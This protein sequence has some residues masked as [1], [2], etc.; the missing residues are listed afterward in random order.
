[1]HG[2]SESHLRAGRPP[3]P[4]RQFA[5]TLQ[6]VHLLNTQFLPDQAA[7]LPFL[8]IVNYG[9]HLGY[10]L[11]RIVGPY[12]PGQ[13]VTGYVGIVD[14]D[15]SAAGGVEQPLSDDA[16]KVPVSQGEDTLF[17]DGVVPGYGTDFPAN[18]SVNIVFDFAQF[19]YPLDG[20][21]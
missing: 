7:D 18:F 13:D 2:L 11:P 19:F 6:E 9:F 20:F 5:R 1:M 4:G 12:L 10:W 14:A 15:L 17:I 21:Q 16:E 8:I 3:L